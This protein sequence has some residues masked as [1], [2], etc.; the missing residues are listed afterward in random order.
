MYNHLSDLE[1]GKIYNI[2]FDIYEA[3]A[4]QKIKCIKILIK[5]KNSIKLE[6]IDTNKIKYRVLDSRKIIYKIITNIENNQL[7]YEE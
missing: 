2:T 6:D 5:L 1:E 3:Y 4:Q 7:Q